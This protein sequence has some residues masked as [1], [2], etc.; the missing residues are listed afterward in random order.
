MIELCLY[1]ALLQNA[2]YQCMNVQIDSFHTVV[3]ALSKIQTENK[4]RAITNKRMVELW[5]L[6]VA[7]LNNELY[8]CI[9]FR[10]DSFYS[11]EIMV[12]T[13]NRS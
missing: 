4:E 1:T 8:Q 10:V 13:N 6:S 11:L 2:F 5:F 12:R 3:M 9:K 7:L